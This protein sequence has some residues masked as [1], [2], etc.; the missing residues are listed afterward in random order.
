MNGAFLKNNRLIARPVQVFREWLEAS[1]SHRITALNLALTVTIGAAIGIGSYVASHKL[2]EGAA[3]RELSYEASLGARQVEATVNVLYRDVSR[4]SSNGVLVQT[5]LQPAGQEEL[6]AAFFSGYIG[7]IGVATE[8]SVHDAQGRRIAGTAGAALRSYEGASWLRRVVNLGFTYT[9]ITGDGGKRFLTIARPVAPSSSGNSMGIL[10]LHAPMADIFRKSMSSFFDDLNKR[11]V[12]DRGET[13][14]ELRLKTLIRPVQAT[15]V[16]PLDLAAFPGQLRLE[17]AGERDEVLAPLR[18]LAAGYAVAAGLILI[19]VLRL[20]RKFGARLN[21]GLARLSSAA[22]SIANGLA[23]LPQLPVTGRDELARVTGAFNA[24]TASVN[25]L[26]QELENRVVKRTVTLQDMNTALVKEILSHKKTGEQLHVA[27]NAIENAAEGVMICDAEE[28]IISV[29]KAFSRITGYSAEDI[30]GATPDMLLTDD[31]SRALHAEI[32]RTVLDEGH[33]KGELWSRRKNGERYLEQCSVS[34]VKDEADRLVNFIILFSDVTKQKEDELRL[35][36]LAHHD[37]LTGLVNR[38]LFQQRCEETLLRAE[39][40]NAKA[41]VIFIDLDHFK[42]VNDSLGHAY[43]DDLLKQAAGRLVECVRKTDVVGRLGGDEFIVLLN[44]VSDSGDVALI[45]KKILDR[46]TASFMIAGHEIFVSASLG[47]SWYPDD[48]QNA[49]T[50]IQNADA[51]MFAAKEQGRNN[52][53]FFSAEMNAQAL[54][55]LMMASSLR[56]AIERE[57]LVLEYQPRIDLRVGRVMG[58]EALV[59]WNHPNLGRIMPGQFIGIAEKTGLIDPLGQWVLRK[60]CQQMM[61]WR[62]SGL[63]PQRVAVN[64][65]AR[66]FM[67]PD[68]TERITGILKETGLE[69]E[70]LELEVTESMVMH[71]PQ[72]A[73][74]ILERLKDMGV[75]I[76]IDDFGTGY[77]S[78]SYLK[79]FPIDYIKI[80]QSFVRGIPLD[81]E[82][83]GITN[84]IIAM[85]K[86]LDVKLIAEGVDNAEQLAFLKNEGCNEGQ[87]YLISVP[88]PAEGLRRFLRTFADSGPSFLANGKHPAVV[89]R[90]AV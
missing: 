11:L 29:N 76:A 56:L 87:G 46:L 90:Q 55:I 40:K 57:E 23:P 69:A 48:G 18:W 3:M 4:M 12:T 2:V 47:I 63:A 74:V 67:Q 61:E 50:L 88:M 60:A 49:A 83:V 25:E 64:L 1:L 21:S 78:L 10:V 35:Q 37:P 8:V 62:R 39:R 51:A 77:S 13:L 34:A 58:V 19:I 16:V 59:R 81:A 72:R 89:A 73:A 68:L 82:D 14:A 45:A 79:R 26:Q 71:D 7:P 38:T 41:A 9:E 70:A 32:S 36:F 53:Q 44:E 33:W 27:A 22:S 80:D 24:V 43:G 65:S 15:Q 86:T 52:Y 85:A 84:A 66:Q 28:R 17:V 5:L 30:L 75:A 31:E 6:L 54:E 42:T 20:S